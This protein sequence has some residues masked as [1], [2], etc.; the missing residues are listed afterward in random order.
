MLT[1]LVKYVKLKNL[2]AAVKPSYNKTF[3]LAKPFIACYP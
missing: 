1:N 3:T 2:F